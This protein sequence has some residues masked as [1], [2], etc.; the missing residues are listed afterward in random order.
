MERFY[1]L[2]S[3]RS[4]SSTVQ[5]RMISSNCIMTGTA[6]GELTWISSPSLHRLRWWA[7]QTWVVSY[8]SY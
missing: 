5:Y 1:S 2:V 8:I 7:F 3:Q 4:A 6:E